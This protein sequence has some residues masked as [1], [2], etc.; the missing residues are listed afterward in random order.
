MVRFLD[1][2]FNR[3]REAPQLTIKQQV[4]VGLYKSPNVAYICLLPDT[5]KLS[6]R[7]KY[8]WQV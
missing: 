6:V 2:R 8:L 3:Y 1:C 5:V 7:R 4:S